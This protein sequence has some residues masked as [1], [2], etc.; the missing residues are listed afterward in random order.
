VDFTR[1]QPA[2]SPPE[3]RRLAPQTIHRLGVDFTRAGVDFTRTPKS[4]FEE[5]QWFAEVI[6]WTLPAQIY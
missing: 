4:K 1:A 6:P 5:N 2:P 3:S